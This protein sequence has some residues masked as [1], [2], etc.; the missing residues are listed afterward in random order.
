MDEYNLENHKK[1]L[2]RKCKL[3]IEN[4]N[5]NSISASEYFDDKLSELITLQSDNN[6]LV[7]QPKN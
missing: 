7:R 2:I 6:T 5:K 1:Q 4:V 3:L